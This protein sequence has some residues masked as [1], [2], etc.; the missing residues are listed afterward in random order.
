MTAAASPAAPGARRRRPGRIELI[1]I[2]GALTAFGPLAVDMYLPALPTLELDLGV[3][4][5]EVQWTLAAAFLGFALG[6]G[7]Y[8]PLADRFGRRPPLVAG[9]LLFLAASAACALAPSIE[10]LIAARF[11]QAVGACAGGVIARAMVRDLFE[12]R[13]TA[14]V[15]S[16][17]MLVMGAAPVLAPL[18]GGQ[19]LA[20]SGWRAIFWVLAGFGALCLVAALA[21]LPESHGGNSGSPLRLRSVV[22]VYGRLLADRRFLAPALAIGFGTGGLFSYI[23]GSPHVVIVLHGV[24]AEHFGWFFGTNAAGLIALSVLN[25]RLVARVGPTRL[26]RI[27]LAVQA[28][29]GVALLAAAAT[30][31]GG[32]WGLAVP[33]FGYVSA[34]GLASPNAGALAMA[35]HGAQAG[36]ASAL[37]GLIQWGTGALAAA[38]MGAAQDGTALPMAATVAICGIAG[39]AAYETLRPGQAVRP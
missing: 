12:V 5:A 2:L 14:R 6:Q 36:S 13:D 21:R 3:T 30:G 1:L 8:G 25:G 11:V 18:L 38:A 17:L 35:S 28:G 10:L 27:G 24:P 37:L 26:L 7:F 31:V 33:L 23:A 19:L 32:L 9:L 29:A 4:A 20:W 15:F 16:A 34:M 39:L 22:L